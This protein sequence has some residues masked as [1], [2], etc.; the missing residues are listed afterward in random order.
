M[1]RKNLKETNHLLDVPHKVGRGSDLLGGLGTDEID[2]D[3]QAK[4]GGKT[5]DRKSGVG[6]A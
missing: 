6:E 4:Q 3:T 1:T 5:G 2:E